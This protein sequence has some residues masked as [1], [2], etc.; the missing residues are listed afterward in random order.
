MPGMRGPGGMWP[1]GMS[2]WGWLWALLLLAIV[3]LVVW[4]AARVVGGSTR[5]SSDGPSD[6]VRIL[7]GRFARGE[8]DQEEFE[9]RRAALRDGDP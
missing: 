5:S 4:V 1:W 7:E 2:G 8:I 9:A 3:V 6:A